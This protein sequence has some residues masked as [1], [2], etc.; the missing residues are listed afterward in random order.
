MATNREK[1]LELGRRFNDLWNARDPAFWE[2]PTPAAVIHVGKAR[3]TVAQAM[4][5]EAP[6]LEAM[7]DCRR[8]ILRETV[9]DD[10]FIHHW[11]CSGRLASDGRLVEWD[12]CTW[13]RIEGRRITEIWIFGDSRD[14]RLE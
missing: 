8:E 5:G 6:L 7:P 1:N 3:P 2:L 4:T 10:H 9:D 13:A 11:R 14:P 12:G